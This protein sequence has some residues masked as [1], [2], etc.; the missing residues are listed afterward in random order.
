MSG[1]L[2]VTS[3]Q[4]SSDETDFSLLKFCYLKHPMGNI[5]YVP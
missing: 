5:A 2:V 1:Y 3:L 4:I